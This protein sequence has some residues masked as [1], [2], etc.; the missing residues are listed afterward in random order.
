MTVNKK[1]SLVKEDQPLYK[2]E[3]LGPSSCSNSELLSIIF[4]QRCS[5]EESLDK[6]K[7]LLN[8]C[9][10]DL[11]EILRISTTKIREVS[12]VSSY[13]ASLLKASLFFAERKLSQ[14]SSV[15]L[16]IK[17]SKD[18]FNKYRY[19]FLNLTAE[20]VWVSYLNRRNKIIHETCVG[21]G[22]LT[23]CVV[24]SH[25]LFRIALEKKAS[26][27][28]IMHNHPSQNTIPSDSDKALCLR[29]REACKILDLNLLDF[30][31][32]ADSSY[33]SFV[34]EGLL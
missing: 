24:D 10:N 15:K 9:N 7:A 17:S 34:D 13:T 27:I 26:N 21:K 32:F 20:E 1:S 30:L 29:F 22:S 33:L 25:E 19:L 12:G 11:Q 28:I 16:S 2:L 3:K 31:I 14:E 18:I 8:Y 6:A 4:Q 5:P 23:K